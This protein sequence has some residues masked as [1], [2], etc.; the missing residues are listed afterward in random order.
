MIIPND[1]AGDRIADPLAGYL[2]AKAGSGVAARIISE[3]PPHLYY[4]E[5]FAGSA[6]VARLKRPARENLLTDR[7]SETVKKLKGNEEDNLTFFEIRCMTWMKALEHFAPRFANP[8]TLLYLDPPYPACVRGRDRYKHDMRN[9]DH[10]R[11]MLLRLLSLK[12][13]VVISSYA[14]E[15]Y[16]GLLADWRR[17]EIPTMTR[18]GKRIEVIWCNFDEPTYLHDPRF[19]GKNHRQRWRIEK[20]RR[21][22]R[23]KY[24][25]LPPAERQLMLETLVEAD[26]EAERLRNF[27]RNR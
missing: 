19:A 22:W 10:H 6:R 26:P 14:N 8:N 7:D 25:A 18:G 16:D 21:R 20:V 9:D 27:Q 23:E 13:M 17:V 12:S 4:A 1:M 15:I 11:T 2:G 3:M 24:L 5:L